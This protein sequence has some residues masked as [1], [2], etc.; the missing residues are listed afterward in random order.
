[1]AMAVLTPTATK[2][3]ASITPIV[4][5]LPE[6]NFVVEA[7]KAVKQ[8]GLRGEVDDE[9]EPETALVPSRSET[10]TRMA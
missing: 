4:I 3:K 2:P 1:M 8:K 10:Q 5:V 6:V 9:K 7:D